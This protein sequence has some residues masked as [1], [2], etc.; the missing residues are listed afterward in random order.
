[1]GCFSLCRYLNNM[2][3]LFL[4][5]TH[6]L[7]HAYLS[8][9]TQTR[10]GS[11]Q[12]L[13]KAGCYPIDSTRRQ[14]WQHFKP[15]IYRFEQVCV[16]D[17]HAEVGDVAMLVL[18]FEVLRERLSDGQGE[19]FLTV[20]E[21][22]SHHVKLIAVLAMS[23]CLLWWPDMRDDCLQK[24]LEQFKLDKF[25]HF[26]SFQECSCTCVQWNRWIAE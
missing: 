2:S 9:H 6:H 18:Q 23:S 14:F 11:S 15:L 17:H 22:Q 13:S 24:I 20:F 10:E 7:L 8:P 21:Q 3:L 1:M 5:A 25:T 16:L 19:S 12:C 26:T 4:S